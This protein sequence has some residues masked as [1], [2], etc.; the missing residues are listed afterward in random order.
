LAITAVVILL[1]IAGTMTAALAV[2]APGHGERGATG[3]GERFDLALTVSVSRKVVPY[4]G[5]LREVMRV[6]NRGTVRVPTS[7]HRRMVFGQE[8]NRP[9]QP[10]Y[11]GKAK[12]AFVRSP[13]AGCSHGNVGPTTI[14]SF[15]CYV[16]P[17]DPGQ[18]QVVRVKIK[19]IRSHLLLDA[20]G[21]YGSSGRIY[22]DRRRN[23]EDPTVIRVRRR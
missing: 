19:N 10:N 18:S 3:T 4:G 7:E 1:S 21:F 14:Q 15:A 9:N 16:T 6:T 17:L 12:Y 22:D 8:L 20:G 13:G 23:D 2:S 5:T 11:P